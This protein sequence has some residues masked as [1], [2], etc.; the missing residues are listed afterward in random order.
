MPRKIDLNW[1][2]PALVKSKVGSERGATGEDGTIIEPCQ[3]LMISFS[4]FIFLF[5]LSISLPNAPLKEGE[6]HLY[7][8]NVWPFSLK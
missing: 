5:S 6:G 1:F 4:S 3:H 8:P 2:I 7:I